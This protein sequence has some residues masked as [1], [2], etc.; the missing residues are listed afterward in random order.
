MPLEGGVGGDAGVVGRVL[1]ARL[2]DEEVS[3]RR[4]DEVAVVGLEGRAVLEPVRHHG[5]RLAARRV[6]PQLRLAPLLNVLVVRRSLELAAQVCKT[7]QIPN[8]T[9]RPK[10]N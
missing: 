6:A 2:Q 9:M 7:N 1:H 8:E 5:L 10:A 4:L 3:G